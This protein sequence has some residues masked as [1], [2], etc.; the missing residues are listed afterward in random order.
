MS[1]EQ[2]ILNQMGV[3]PL[4]YGLEKCFAPSTHQAG[5]D[6]KHISNHD[7]WLA[8]HAAQV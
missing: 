5:F 2:Q 7:F 8:L 1:C 3:E 4:N 6:A